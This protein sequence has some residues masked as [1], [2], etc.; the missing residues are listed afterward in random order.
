[1][2]PRFPASSMNFKNPK[3][4]TKWVVNSYT[5]S[6][7]FVNAWPASQLSGVM[8]WSLS[9]ATGKRPAGNLPTKC[10]ALLVDFFN[11]ASPPVTLLPS[12]LS[13]GSLSKLLLFF[14]VMINVN[15]NVNFCYSDMYMEW[16][17]AIAFVGGIAAPLNYRWVSPHSSLLSLIYTN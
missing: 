12:L 5:R 8:T 4:T 14:F 1:M 6:P 11:S 9:P 2:I 16:L 17:L 7:T 13:T 10:C 3:K 15:V